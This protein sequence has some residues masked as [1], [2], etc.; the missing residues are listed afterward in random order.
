MRTDVWC[1]V[2]AVPLVIA[3]IA[4]AALL[5][6]ATAAGPCF[7]RD[8]LHAHLAERYGERPVGTGVAAVQLVEL[9]TR[10]DGASWTIV[11]LRPG[12]LACP[13]AVGEDWTDVRKP[14]PGGDEGS[15]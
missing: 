7:P 14:D 5:P 8:A 1:R 6:A 3:F 9:L 10:P 13:L 12:G 15:S 11:V 2:F 4:A